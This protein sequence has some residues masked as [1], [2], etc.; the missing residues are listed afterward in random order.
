MTLTGVPELF[1]LG[2]Q[3]L[4]EPLEV[5]VLLVAAFLSTVVV[6]L[7]AAVLLIVTEVLVAPVVLVAT[8]LL[9]QGPLNGSVFACVPRMT[10]F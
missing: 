9:V 3:T 8:E 4:A 10:V 5:A 2:L 1:V 6:L 7:V